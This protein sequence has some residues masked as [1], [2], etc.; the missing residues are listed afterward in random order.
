[1]TLDR[2]FI[3]SLPALGDLGSVPPM[4]FAELWEWLADHRRIRPLAGALLLMDDLQQREAYLA[5]EID[6]LEPTVLSLSQTL[7]RS[8]LPAYLAPEAG[9]TSSS[10][11]RIASDQLWESY[12]RYVAQLAAE[13]KSSFLAA[14]V[15]HEVALRNALAAARAE[16]L[17]LEPAAYFVAPDLAQTD[18]DFGS[19]LGE[20]AAATSPLAG[21]QRLLRAKWGWIEAHDPHFTF[22]DDELLVY[23]ARLILLKQ[24]QRIAGNE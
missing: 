20:W 4:G 7:G 17:G 18:D 21:Q 5:G 6:Y 24:W 16:R 14:W 9:E 19:L 2:Y 23:T 15:G 3:T 10:P 22:D 13:R 12:F 11:R 8:P 1:M